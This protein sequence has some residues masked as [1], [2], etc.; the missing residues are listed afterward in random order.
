M[1][2]WFFDILAAC[3]PFAAVACTG[4]TPSEQSAGPAAKPPKRRRIRRWLFNIL[5]AVSLVICLATTIL[6][7]R[8]IRT[9]DIIFHE[10]SEPDD[11]YFAVSESGAIGVSTNSPI[12]GKNGWTH[13]KKDVTENLLSHWLWFDGRL[14]SP[15]GNRYVRIPIL[16]LT[17]I[18]LVPQA[19]FIRRWRRERHAKMVGHCLTCNYNLTGN[20]SGTC[21]E[22]GTAIAARPPT[23]AEGA[24]A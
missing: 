15:P 11:S 4:G 9:A 6:A 1:K 2:S 3:V 10:R 16:L 21:P 7:I 14:T 8:S 5:A 20:V 23:Q 24:S 17:F 18:F 13:L 19:L 22:C 12:F